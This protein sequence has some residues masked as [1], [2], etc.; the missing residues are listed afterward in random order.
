M[1]SHNRDAMAYYTEQAETEM[2]DANTYYHNPAKTFF[3]AQ[4][5]GRGTW[6]S[7]WENDFSKPE[8]RRTQLSHLYTP[9]Q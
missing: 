5:K 4:V 3:D 7:L 2:K 6:A 9:P 8:E 1:Q